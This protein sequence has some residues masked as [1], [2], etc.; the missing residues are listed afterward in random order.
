MIAFAFMCIGDGSDNAVDLAL[1]SCPIRRECPPLKWDYFRAR[2]PQQQCNKPI[3]Q[4][5]ECFAMHYLKPECGPPNHVAATPPHIDAL[6]NLARAVANAGI[7]T[8]Q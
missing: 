8:K 6:A 2:L 1:C 7:R 3:G 4:A 5:C